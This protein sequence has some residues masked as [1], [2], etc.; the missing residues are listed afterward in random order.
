[1]NRLVDKDGYPTPKLLKYIREFDIVKHKGC[2]ELLETL[3]EVW[4]DSGCCVTE[5]GRTAT[6]LTL[7][8]GGWSGNEDIMEALTSNQLFWSL[9]W[10]RSARGGHYYFKIRRIK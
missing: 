7:H 9:Y 1:M 5:M 8:T 10:E 2:D 6:H 4:H 3:E